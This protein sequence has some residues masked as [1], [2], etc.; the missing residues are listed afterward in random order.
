P[1]AVP[2]ADGAAP[3]RD[4]PRPRPRAGSPPRTISA[5]ERRGRALLAMCIGAPTLGREFLERLTPEHLSSEL[6]RRTRAWLADHLEAPLVGLERD[7]EELVAL[8][9]DLTMRAE[10][11]PATREA[12][13][14]NFLELDLR[15]VEDRIAAAER[16]GGSPPVDLQRQRAALKERV[17]GREALSGQERP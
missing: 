16:A 8:V 5:R 4:A 2:P 11:E 3:A 7:D 12:M 6:I 1:R 14:N 15:R 10:R 17:F 9:T 13:E